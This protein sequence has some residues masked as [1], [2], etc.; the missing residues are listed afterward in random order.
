MEGV[1]TTTFAKDAFNKVRV[2]VITYPTLPVNCSSS[3][4]LFF[5][6]TPGQSL[7]LKL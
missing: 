3:T 2:T 4:K 7:L 6:I 5:A 1:L